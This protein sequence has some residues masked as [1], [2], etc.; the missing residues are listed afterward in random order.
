MWWHKGREFTQEDADG[1]TGF[2]YLI[3][4]LETG[5]K[6]VGKKRLV[7]SRKIRATKKKRAHRTRT[8]SD[9]DTYWSSSDDVRSD[10]DTLG[11]DKFFREIL[12]LCSSLGEMSYLELKEQIDRKV[13]LREDYYNS[14][15]GARIHR[16][17]LR[18]NA[19]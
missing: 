15:I 9:W 13:L 6:Y 17:H 16:N 2:V 19:K 3:T 14:Y 10:V 11:E 4:N 12:H 1:W 8:T 5:K 18:S 7:R